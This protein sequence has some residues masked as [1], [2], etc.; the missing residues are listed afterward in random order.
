MHLYLLDDLP[1]LD[2]LHN[3]RDMRHYNTDMNRMIIDYISEKKYVKSLNDLDKKLVIINTKNKKYADQKLEEEMQIILDAYAFKYHVKK[4]FIKNNS[5]NLSGWALSYKITSVELYKNKKRIRYVNLKKR[6]DIYNKYPQYK[7][8]K[9]GFTFK[10]IHLS[11]KKDKFMLVF[12]NKNRVIKK[13]LITLQKGKNA[14]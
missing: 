5:V 6:Q 4:T 9:S 12:K 10:D 13:K 8:L 11:T 7:Q 14:Q 2:D 3:Y 1:Y